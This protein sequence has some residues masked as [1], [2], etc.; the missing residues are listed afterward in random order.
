[1]RPIPDTGSGLSGFLAHG[2]WQV[3]AH[4][5]SP[6]GRD[7]LL[8]FLTLSTLVHVVFLPYLWRHVSRDMV[9]LR[10]GKEGFPAGTMWIMYWGIFWLCYFLW[11]FQTLAGRTF[12]EKRDLGWIPGLTRTPLTKPYLMLQ[13]YAVLPLVV[14]FVSFACLESRLIRRD[15]VAGITRSRPAARR[16]LVSLYAGGGTFVHWVEGVPRVSLAR[17]AFS[18]A[19]LMVILCHV[20]YWFWSSASLVLMYC[21]LL[22]AAV[23]EMFRILFVYILHKRTFG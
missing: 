1:M 3:Y 20:F 6:G 2:R 4:F 12:L 13:L 10:E 22:A 21:F 8:L 16:D 18:K 15:R 5:P 9:R 14:L 11:F 7:W 23:S 17:C 19:T